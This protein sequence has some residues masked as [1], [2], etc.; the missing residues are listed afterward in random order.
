LPF[1]LWTTNFDEF[2]HHVHG[3]GG[4]FV[5]KHGETSEVASDETVAWSIA[6]DKVT[7]ETID[8]LEPRG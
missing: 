8:Q 5:E 7:Q 2:R 4:T 1:A 6:F 3:Q